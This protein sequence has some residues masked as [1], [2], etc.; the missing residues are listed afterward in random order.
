MK[1]LLI[2]H[3]YPPAVDG[4]SK[5]ISKIGEYFKKNGHQI[6]VL[7]SNCQSTDDFINPK[8]KTSY[9]KEQ[10]NI[11]K[12][13]VY[14]A[15]RRP[16][17]LICLFFPKNS[18]FRHFL[19][20]FQ[21]GP[22][23]KFIPFFKTLIQIKK[24]HP[25]LIICGPLPTTIILYG[26]LIKK[27][28]RSQILINASFHQTDQDFYKKPLIKTLKS[29]DLIWSLGKYEK[30]FFIKKLNV[31]KNK[32]LNI[33]NGIDNDFIINKNKIEF[34]KNPNILFIGSFASHKRVDLLI[35]TFKDI[36]EKY[37]NIKL[38]LAGQKT[39][40]YPKIKNKIKNKNIKIIFN[41][42]NQKL[43]KII[44]KSTVL[45]LPST[46]E[47]FGLVLIESMARG[48]PVIA[49]NIPP[50]KELIKKTQGG[51]TFKTNSQKNLTETI[52][53]IINNKKLAQKLGS[54]GLDYVSKHYTW[55]KIG[56]QIWQKIS[57]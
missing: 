43:K 27:I 29:A 44:D 52:I 1:I 20:V 37:P 33:G 32:I 30:D 36:L 15:L 49:S 14:K 26:N 48:K 24:F 25:D 50:I 47:S 13:S 22:I 9:Q 41:F 12:I 31:N 35:D 46:Q 2:T 11:Y 3:I 56:K 39:L 54:N 45:I 28:C 10:K 4:G 53:K 57:S 40:Y 6:M 55:D 17:K 51:L 42:S 21:K 16:L 7:T 8:S 34:P 38:T 18:H 19:E 23:F 5:V